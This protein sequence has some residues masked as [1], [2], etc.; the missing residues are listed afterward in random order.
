[1]GISQTGRLVAVKRV[2]YKLGSSAA[3]N[4]SYKPLHESFGGGK[5][6]GKSQARKIRRDV[7]K[8]KRNKRYENFVIRLIRDLCREEGARIFYRA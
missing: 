8:K 2:Y 6:S 5:L 3:I 7:Q 1:M 4:R